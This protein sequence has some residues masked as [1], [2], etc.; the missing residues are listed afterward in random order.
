MVLALIWPFALNT[1]QFSDPF[2]PESEADC[3]ECVEAKH[4]WLVGLWVA[5]Q[6]SMR[7]CTYLLGVLD[8]LSC[9]LVSNRPAYVDAFAGIET[10]MSFNVPKGLGTKYLVPK[11]LVSAAHKK[12]L[13]LN[14]SK[15]KLV[16]DADHI[17]ERNP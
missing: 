14:M 15:D 9:G 7:F 11:H 3:P 12:Y 13:L 6:N 8:Y 2:V 5:F 1:I 17:N 10:R 16:N 4:T